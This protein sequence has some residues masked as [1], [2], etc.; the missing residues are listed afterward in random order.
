MQDVPGSVYIPVNCEATTA[1]MN[2][3][4]QAL[5]DNRSAIRTDLACVVRVHGDQFRTSFFH[6]VRKQLPEQAQ[7]RVVCGEG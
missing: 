7:R 3:N 6:F 5:S 4:S 2:A 1:V